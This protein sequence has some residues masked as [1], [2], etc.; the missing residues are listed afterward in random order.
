ML[1]VTEAASVAFWCTFVG[2]LPRVLLTLVAIAAT[3]SVSAAASVAILSFF[4]GGLPRF[5]VVLDAA[6]IPAD[7]LLHEPEARPICRRRVVL[8]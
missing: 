2:G 6:S 8:L 7:T 4:D 3:L 1:S 5:F